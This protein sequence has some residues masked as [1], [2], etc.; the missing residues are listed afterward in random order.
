[1]TLFLDAVR[2]T[3]RTANVL[4]IQNGSR[5]PEVVEWY[6]QYQADMVKKTSFIQEKHTVNMYHSLPGQEAGRKSVFDVTVNEPTL[7]I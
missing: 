4:G 1:V 3:I 5:D 7:P 2:R 6:F